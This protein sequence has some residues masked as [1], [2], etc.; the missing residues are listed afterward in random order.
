MHRFNHE[1]GTARSPSIYLKKKKGPCCLVQHPGCVEL[2]RQEIE[3]RILMKGG[4]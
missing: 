4:Q 3:V 1:M 2:T